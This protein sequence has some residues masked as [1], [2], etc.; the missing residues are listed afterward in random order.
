MVIDMNDSQLTALAQIRD[1][2]TGTAGVAFAPA[3][4]DATRFRFIAQVLRRFGCPTLARLDKG[5]IRRYLAPHHRLFA[6]QLTRLLR[7]HRQAGGLSQRYAAPKAGFRRHYTAAEVSL[8]AEVDALHGTLPGPATRV[9][10]ERA[11]RVYGDVRFERLAALA[12]AHLY[13][14]RQHAAYRKVRRHWT[15]TRPTPAAIGVRKPP[16]PDGRPSFIR[17]DSVHQGDQD[18]PQGPVPHQRRGLR[19]PVAVRGH[20]RAHY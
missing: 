9:L 11:P 12:V 16:R 20:D 13:N 10:L 6:R 1:F 19:H 18:R 2:L 15:R 8:L 14:L 4:D 5:L 17:I 7:R 3:A